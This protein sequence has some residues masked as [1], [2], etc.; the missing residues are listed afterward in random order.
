MESED[1]PK[2]SWVLTQMSAL[3]GSEGMRILGGFSPYITNGE[4][5]RST[6]VAKD[7]TVLSTSGG[8]A[9]DEMAFMCGLAEILRP[10][11]I[12]IIGNSYG[13]STLLLALINPKSSLV[14][15]DKFRTIGIEVTNRMLSSLEGAE[16]IQASTPDD[17]HSI[18][19]NRLEGS[20]DF[21]FVDAVHENAVQ[22]AEFKILEPIMSAAGVVVFH[23]VLSCNL[24]PSIEDLQAEFA[25][26]RFT[27]CSRTTT[28]LG[29]GFRRDSVEVERYLN[30]WT[31]SA[32]DINRFGHLMGTKWGDS[33]SQLFAEVKTDLKFQ[34]HPQL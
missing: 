17:L 31:S 4:A 2:L 23:D 32:E 13:I 27:V 26:W 15:I 24:L 10:E 21:V 9:V 22:S 18:V 12:L 8:I 5:S 14:A 1:F 25:E 19:L 28:G 6:F 33:A 20:V 7:A 16:V 29:V 30:F 11:R 34:P 3:Y